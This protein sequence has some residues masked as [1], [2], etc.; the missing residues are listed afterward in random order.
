[1]AD[2][3]RI[4]R[5]VFL[6]YRKPAPDEKKRCHLCAS[7]VQSAAIIGWG[8]IKGYEPRCQEI[9]FEDDKSQRINANHCCR[10]F[11]LKEG[12]KL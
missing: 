1:M 11:K 5:K 6:D 2:R 10:A 7:F 3:F 8:G 9:G 12:K 4:S